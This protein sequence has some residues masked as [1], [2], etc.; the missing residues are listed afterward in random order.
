MLGGKINRQYTTETD[1]S[2]LIAIN[3]EALT[4][5]QAD[6]CSVCNHWTVDPTIVNG[7]KYCR[8]CYAR[9]QQFK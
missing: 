9:S 1:N 2:R 5:S 8:S 7:K 6:F 4:K 3:K